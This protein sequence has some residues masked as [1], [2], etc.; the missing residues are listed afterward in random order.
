MKIDEKS[1]KKCKKSLVIW[2][3]QDIEG[4]GKRVILVDAVIERIRVCFL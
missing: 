4:M 3:H 2:L 1:M